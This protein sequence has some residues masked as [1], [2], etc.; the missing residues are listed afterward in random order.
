MIRSVATWAR[1]REVKEERPGREEQRA[2]LSLRDPVISP[3]VNF[4]VKEFI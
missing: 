2:S 4:E 3:V 1:L